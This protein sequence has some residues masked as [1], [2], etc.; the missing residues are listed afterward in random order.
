MDQ[1]DVPTT[2]PPSTPLEKPRGPARKRVWI[3][4]GAVVAVAAAIWAYS[5]FSRPSLVGAWSNRAPQNTVAFLFKEDG[6]GAMSIGDAQLPYQYRFD[7]THNPA[8][9]DLEARPNGRPV[10]IR[11]IAKFA[12][13][14]KLIIRMPH[15]RS[16]GDRPA[17][18]IP[19]DVE[20]TILLTRVESDS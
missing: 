15:T 11:A 14:G 6:S 4:A 13:G 19:D 12:R 20:N 1:H 16:P 17:E 9:L 10:T 18:F 8:W 7:R 3:L 5:T 2:T